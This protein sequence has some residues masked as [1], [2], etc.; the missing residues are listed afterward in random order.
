MDAT[1][2]EH[3]VF[4]TY[5]ALSDFLVYHAIYDTVMVLSYQTASDVDDLGLP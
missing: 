4:Q 1:V 2:S 3:L 5:L